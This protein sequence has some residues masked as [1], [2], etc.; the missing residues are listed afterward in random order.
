MAQPVRKPNR[1]AKYDYSQ[2][3]AYFITVCIKDKVPML[4]ACGVGAATCRPQIEL[5][6]IG[7]TVETAIRQISEKYTR[8]SVDRYCIMPNHVHLILILHPSGR[9][10]RQVAAP[11]VSTIVGNMKRWVSIQTGESVWQKGFYDHIIR[12]EQDYL[13]KAQYIDNNPAAWLEK[14]T[15]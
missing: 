10:G 7:R 1:L 14:H 2:N 5:S 15:P 13:T 8:V 4:W 3:G 11:T 9:D 6:S 12:D